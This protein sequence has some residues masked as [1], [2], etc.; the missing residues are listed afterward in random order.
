MANNIQ[1]ALE[2]LDNRGKYQKILMIILILIYIEL[3]FILL[4][5]PFYYMNPIFKC[6][7]ADSDKYIETPE[8]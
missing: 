8:N 1:K 2:C 3:G 7:D 4:G 5:A 6:K